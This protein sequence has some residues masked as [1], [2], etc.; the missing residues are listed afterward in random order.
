MRDQS[1]CRSSPAALTRRRAGKLDSERSRM[2]QQGQHWHRELR[3]DQICLVSIDVST[4]R[5]AISPSCMS[6][7]QAAMSRYLYGLE[8]GAIQTDLAGMAS[9]GI[10]SVVQVH[11]DLVP[12]LV[13]SPSLQDVGAEGKE[14]EGG[15]P[16]SKP[17]DGV[18]KWLGERK[19]AKNHWM[20]REGALSTSKRVDERDR[21]AT[22]SAIK[23]L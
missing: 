15:N 9:V 16:P 13:L 2:A 21:P 22:S 12:V 10:R 23:L 4:C 5:Q 18:R 8:D 19:D 17:Q 14:A 20:G 7:A 3:E 11:L 6:C 1:G